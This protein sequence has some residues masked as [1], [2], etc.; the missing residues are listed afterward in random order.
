VIL[1]LLRCSTD[2]DG[3]NEI[4]IGYTD[5]LVRAY[6]WTPDRTT[7]EEPA[8]TSP[9]PDVSAANISSTPSFTAVLEETPTLS[10]DPSTIVSGAA[11][12]LVEVTCKLSETSIVDELLTS[13]KSN[14]SFD[15][16][17]K[18]V[19]AADAVNAA[20]TESFHALTGGIDNSSTS[21]VLDLSDSALPSMDLEGSSNY[22]NGKLELFEEWQLAGQV[23]SN[24][25]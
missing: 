5:R 15:A 24:S 25:S 14:S 18:A 11:S 12:T 17:N 19:A 10:P 3:Q 2:G 21:S 9:S 4:V 22:W 1:L 13:V 16:A 7:T 8:A 6:K 20:S 23:L